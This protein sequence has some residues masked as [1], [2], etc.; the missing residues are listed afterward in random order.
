MLFFSFS[1]K[2]KYAIKVS[3]SMMLAYLIPLW[4]GWEQAPTGAITIMLIAATGRVGDSVMKGFLRVV[5]TV[6]GATIGM[7]LIALFPQER[8]LYL[9]SLSICVTAVLYILRAYKGDPSAFML[10]AMTMMM[11]FKDG[12]VSDVF[13]YG[14]DKTY[15]TIFGIVVY[16]AVGIFIWPVHLE[17]TSQASAKA[18]S[19]VQ[20][21]LFSQRAVSKQKRTELLSSLIEHENKLLAANRDTGNGEVTMEQWHSMIS[22]YQNINAILSLLTT[23]HNTEDDPDMSRFIS[24]Y[25]QL[26]AEIS[27]LFKTLATVWTDKEEIV[28][29]QEITL[30]YC[31]DEIQSLSHIDR[32]SLL[33][34]LQEMKKLHEALRH[35]AQKINAIQSPLPTFFNDENIPQNQRFLWG[36]I[37]HIKAAFVTFLI[38]WTATFFWIEMNPFG[39]F[40]VVVLAT[41]LSVLTTFTPLKPSLLIIVFTVSFIFATLMYIWVLPNLHYGW[42]LG[43]F[44]FFYAFIAFYLIPQKVSIL[45]LLGLFILGI[46]NVM[47]YNFSIF[48]L[49]LLMFYLFLIILHIFYY[50]PFSTKPEKLF[51]TLKKR[52]FTLAYYL[53][54]RAKK[55]QEGQDTLRFCLLAKYSHMHLMSTSKKMQLWASQIDAGYF[56]TI[57]KDALLVYSKECEKVAYILGLLYKHEINTQSNPLVT[58]LREKYTLPFLSDLLD[59]YAQGKIKKD[60]SDFWNNEEKIVSM[61]EK[62]LS[63]ILSP[64]EF[65]AYSKQEIVALYENISLRRDVWLALFSLQEKSKAIDFKQLK[66]GRF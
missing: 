50:I 20:A 53:L 57:D 11:V 64:I 66:R 42:E 40:M 9:L 14:I 51:V 49:L 39:G 22:D 19:E 25:T 46:N 1:D 16:S 5:G 34:T 54:E 44:I 12:A 62:S 60:V 23:R 30:V 58:I 48:L 63:D 4:Q 24:N 59:Q 52:F 29:P 32:A 43:L 26:N 27:L 41:G 6:I 35:L 2:M 18:L 33:S 28:I 55:H 8:L 45:F 65:S 47:Y 10:T 61:V 56:D 36:D 31:Q 13:L 38:F 37:E 21:E 17:D 15:M 7:T 3:L